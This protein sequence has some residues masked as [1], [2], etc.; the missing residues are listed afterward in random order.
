MK[1]PIEQA[2]LNIL[3]QFCK[4]HDKKYKR[5]YL[6]KELKISAQNLSWWLKQDRTKFTIGFIERIEA[7]DK[8]L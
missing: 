7:L 4:K 1:E 2:E 5:S 8:E 3:A 6:A